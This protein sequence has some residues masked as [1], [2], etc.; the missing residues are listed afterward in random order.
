MEDMLASGQLK[1]DAMDLGKK[2][3]VE[4]EL[5]VQH[6][7]QDLCTPSSFFLVAYLVQVIYGSWSASTG[8]VHIR[9]CALGDR[10][11]Q[12][13][14]AVVDP[15]GV[16]FDDIFRSHLP[17]P[18]HQQ[19]PKKKNTFS[20]VVLNQVFDPLDRTE[21]CFRRDSSTQNTLFS[22][23]IEPGF[24]RLGQTKRGFDE[25]HTHPHLP[26]TFFRLY[27]SRLPTPW[28]GKTLSS[29]RADTSSSTAPCWASRW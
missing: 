9:A 1:M 29:M 18:P 6:V 14:H 4:K 10:V 5:E 26:D 17:T 24:R 16:C 15:R 11:C 2:S 3:A 20:R 27:G 25:N 12:A 8:Y 28:T 22:L 13:F 7:S 23:F 21:G 19:Q